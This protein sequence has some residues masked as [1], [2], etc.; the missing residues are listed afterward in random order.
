MVSLTGAQNAQPIVQQITSIETAIA[1]L[2]AVINA[3]GATIWKMQADIYVGAPQTSQSLA[4]QYDMNAADS[5][6]ILNAVLTGLQN[7]L[8]T[9]NA[10]LAEIT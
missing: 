5:G 10:Q 7:E 1:A 9:L 8:A 4:L 6:N 2:Q 3:G